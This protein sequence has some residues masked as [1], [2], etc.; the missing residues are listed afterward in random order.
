LTLISFNRLPNKERE[1][2][3]NEYPLTRFIP[4]EQEG[5]EVEEFEYYPGM[6]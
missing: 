1:P 5:M 4:E 6:G 3:P 2:H